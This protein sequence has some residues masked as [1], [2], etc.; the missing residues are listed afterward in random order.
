[1]KT[2]F[3]PRL[4]LRQKRAMW[5]WVFSAPFII[6][7][8]LFFLAPM[9]Q[10]I[11]FAFHKLTI[12]ATGFTLENVGWENFRYALEVDADFIQ[13]FTETTLGTFINIPA[14]IIFSFFAATLLNQR[15]KG[16]ALAR[17]IF[18]LPV[19]LT[20]GVIFELESVDVLHNMRA[21]V[22]DQQG[23]I[24]GSQFL[25]GLMLRLQMPASFTNYI[26]WA[27]M[28]IPMIINASAIPILIFLAGLQ[29]IPASLF[30]CAKIEGATGWEMFWKITFPL[31]SPLFLTNIVYI[32]V[33]SFT[34]PSNTLVDH[35]YNT[36]WMRNMFGASVAMT[37]MYFAAIAVI[38][39]LVFAILSRRVIYMEE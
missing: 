8:I 27:V 23:M 32:I 15:F 13:I 24:S 36:A 33:D 4:T 31:I 34:T 19:I 3:K 20:A 35:I 10:A 38:V 28:Q 9:I 1:M 5:G 2:K 26:I 14:I 39:A 12:T 37:L 18:F 29:G 17:V 16:R 7:F 6:G 11:Q 25:I 22:P 21:F 30:E